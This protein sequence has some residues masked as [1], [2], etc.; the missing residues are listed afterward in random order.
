MT[1]STTVANTNAF[2]N[3]SATDLDVSRLTELFSKV[4]TTQKACKEFGSN[5]KDMEKE[6]VDK[7]EALQV[8][9]TANDMNALSPLLAR[10]KELEKKLLEDPAT[11]IEAFDKA[12]NAFSEHLKT[13]SSSLKIVATKAA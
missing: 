11:K 6:N 7:R 12:V 2:N 1:T 13:L 9:L 4:R 5:F 10:V 3:V 8:A